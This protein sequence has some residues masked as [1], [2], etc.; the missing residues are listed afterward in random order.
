ME[1]ADLTVCILSYNR[2]EYL[3]ECINSVKCQTL[4]PGR[5]IIYDNGSSKEVFEHIKP[6]LT[7]NIIWRGSE[8][9]YGVIWNYNRSVKDLTTEYVMVF[10]DDD[11][12][13]EFFIERQFEFLEN[14]KHLNII[15]LSCNGHSFESNKKGTTIF[16]NTAGYLL[17]NTQAEIVSH[18]LS[19]CIPISPVIFRSAIFESV[20]ID[21]E[22]GKCCDVKLLLDAVNSGPIVI[23]YEPLYDCRLHLGQDSTSFPLDDIIR[24]YKLYREIVLEVMHKDKSLINDVRHNFTYLVLSKY[25]SILKGKNKTKNLVGSLRALTNKNY[26]VIAMVKLFFNKIKYD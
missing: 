14:A 11:R 17:F 3:F 24:L 13:N 23:N 15:A 10:H 26:S 4:L 1:R 5:V 7:P 22:Y 16:K 12:L 8:K 18:C 9:N 20:N 19:S 2:K 25:K 21:Y 6:L